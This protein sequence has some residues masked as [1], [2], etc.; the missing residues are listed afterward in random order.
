MSVLDV[1]NKARAL[2]PIRKRG[3]NSELYHALVL[4][5]QA[6][7]ICLADI[8]EDWA[9]SEAIAALPKGNKNRQYVERGSDAYQRVCRYVFWSEEHTA[10][11]NRYAITL[12]E[13]SW[14]SPS[15]R[16]WRRE[17]QREIIQ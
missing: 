17:K 8:N 6:S 7:E 5:M 13:A 9:L 1:I 10:N 11:I 12:R 3:A 16:E 2:M 14:R 15:T 4:A